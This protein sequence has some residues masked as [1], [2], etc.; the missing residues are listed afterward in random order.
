M[1]RR[2]YREGRAT[3]ELD[4]R[5]SALLTIDMQDELSAAD[6]PLIGFPK[7]LASF[8]AWLVSSRFAAHSQF[9]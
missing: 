3:F 7:L 6:G 8:R 2:A 9:R 1:A 4:P 5:R